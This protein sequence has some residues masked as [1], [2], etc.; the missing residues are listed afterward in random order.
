MTGGYPAEADINAF[1]DDRGLEL[2]TE[3]NENFVAEFKQC[4]WGILNH[5]DWAGTLAVY[6]QSTTTFNVAAGQYLYRGEVKTYTPGS[7][8]NPTDNDTTYV[9]LT[10]ANAV[11]SGIDGSGWPST[12]HIKLAEI[13]VDSGGVITDVR[14]LR[15]RAF[16]DYSPID[17]IIDRILTYEGDVLTYEGDVIYY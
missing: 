6:C 11:A 4:I 16:M 2:L 9:W 13:D 3:N 1:L 5:L 8:I 17:S 12:E 7:A 14:D 15:G 10:P